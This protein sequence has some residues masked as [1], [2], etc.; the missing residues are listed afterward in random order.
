MHRREHRL[1]AAA[2]WDVGSLGAVVLLGQ[3]IGELAEHIGAAG[4]VKAHP[5]LS[6]SIAWA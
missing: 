3:A 2:L 4:F 5:L 1:E 6:L